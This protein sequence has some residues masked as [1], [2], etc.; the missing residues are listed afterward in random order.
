MLKPV[1]EGQTLSREAGER[2]AM[3]RRGCIL[4]G[5]GGE[6]P[7]AG[8]PPE[9][10]LQGPDADG[11]SPTSHPRSTPLVHSPPSSG[12]GSAL[13]PAAVSLT[14][15]SPLPHSAATLP[16]SEKSGWRQLFSLSNPLPTTWLHS[17]LVTTCPLCC[18][19]SAFPQL[20][21]SGKS[22]SQ[23]PNPTAVLSPALPS[24]GAFPRL[25]FDAT[26]LRAAAPIPCDPTGSQGFTFNLC[27]NSQFRSPAPTS[28]LKAR[29]YPVALS[30]I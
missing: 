20:C 26:C 19:P 24:A 17:L 14:D 11:G 1:K 22:S 12:P 18:H 8:L 15:L 9:A 2:P 4:Q 23:W 25:D 28:S 5:R 27:Y 30:Q 21:S 13:P 3:G 6:A 29:L 10:Y 16:F 7:G